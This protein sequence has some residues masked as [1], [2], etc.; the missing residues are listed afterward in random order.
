MGSWLIKKSVEKQ[1]VN[2]VFLDESASTN[3]TAEDYIEFKS[4]GKGIYSEIGDTDPFTYTIVDE[5]KKITVK[6]DGFYNDL[7]TYDIKTLNS[8]DL[9][10]YTESTY[11][12]N[13]A[14]DKYTEELTLKRK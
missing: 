7:E 3:F 10:I 5:G 11:T 2:G 13:G 4:D 8:T 1:Y 6:Y 9:I 12:N 14:T